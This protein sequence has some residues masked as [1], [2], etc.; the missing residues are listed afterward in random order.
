M[1]VKHV[2]IFASKGQSNDK[3][4][5][6]QLQTDSKGLKN[7]RYQQ[8]IETLLQFKCLSLGEVGSAGLLSSLSTVYEFSF[9]NNKWD[10]D[11]GNNSTAETS[12]HRKL[13]YSVRIS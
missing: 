12:A 1:F 9:D 7:N 5:P 2:A 4:A 11:C 6:A 10:C 3:S 13:S 8:L